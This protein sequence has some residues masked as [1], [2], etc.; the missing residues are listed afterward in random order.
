MRSPRQACTLL[1]VL[2]GAL[3][4][5]AGDG[6]NDGERPPTADSSSAPDTEVTAPE[7]VPPP[8]FDGPV[9]PDV[10]PDPGPP[11]PAP[12]ITLTVAEI[13]PEMN[14][15]RPYQ[16]EAP[17]STTFTLRVNRE[18][19]QLDVLANPE[20]GPLDWSTLV[21]T[22]DGPLM[23]PPAFEAAGE[24]HQRVSITPK[25][26]RAAGPS[27]CV[28]T[29]S[30][31][32]G[33]AESALTIELA[34][35]PTHLD[36]FVTPDIW[37]IVLSRDLFAISTQPGPEGEITVVSDYL[38]KG[39]GT[40]DLE[41]AL[42][43]TGLYHPP[44]PEAAAWVRTR[45]LD[46]VRAEAESIFAGVPITLAFEG[47]PGAPAAADFA[48]GGFS[49]IAFSGDGKPGIKDDALGRALIDWNNQGHEDDTVYG[50]GIFV[51]SAIR[52][53]LQN[54]A[55]AAL[56]SEFLPGQGQPF[57]THPADATI[58]APDFDPETTDDDEARG[59]YALLTLIV[60]LAARGLASVLCHE[61][62][63]SLGLVPDGPPP[64]GLFAGV[65]TDFTGKVFTD[66][67]IDTDGLN[68][69]QTGA[70]TDLMGAASL[71]P[72]FNP[73]V[74]AYLTRQLVVGS[75]AAAPL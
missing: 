20:A 45:L 56:L 18:R 73:L 48:G 14:G 25:S 54:P 52:M 8:P 10:S 32:G 58:L 19:F 6:S 21:L 34:T 12:K 24:W 39:N 74:R 64:H 13:P 11:P 69:M 30:G 47:D 16:A 1:A 22:C 28:A 40:P 26:P 4:S 75:M 5:C 53:V 27:N 71:V 65:D 36:P 37:L 61:I 51:T 42:A 49:M 55:G 63:H 35:M 41:E 67:H 15:S 66:A 7:D 33:A 44:A 70:V 43:L 62:G 17:E 3:I 23:D 60:D 57:G 72:S 59:R 38:P 2:L 29:V 9:M 31:P 50:L 68:V 46:K